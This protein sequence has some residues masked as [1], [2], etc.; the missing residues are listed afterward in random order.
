MRP[1]RATFRDL[2]GIPSS[3]GSYEIHTKGGVPLKAGISGNLRK[4][5]IQ[6]GD[7]KQSRLYLE[8]GG[9]RANPGDVRSKQSILAK[10]PIGLAIRDSRKQCSRVSTS[11]D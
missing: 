3:T 11:P 10:H 1:R 4:R 7:S 8:P 5:L 2:E 6:H 9:T